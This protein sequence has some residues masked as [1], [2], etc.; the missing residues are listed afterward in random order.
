MH[1]WLKLDT[2]MPV[3]QMMVYKH[4]IQHLVVGDAR[5][6]C[7]L[8]S[9]VL[10]TC[11]VKCISFCEKCLIFFEIA[12]FIKTDILTTDSIYV[13]GLVRHLRLY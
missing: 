8:R 1:G 10:F 7:A 5:T 11:E 12:E 6:Q 9:R 3:S 13:H 2:Q 4:Y